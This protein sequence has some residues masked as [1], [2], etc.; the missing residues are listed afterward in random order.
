MANIALEL[1]ILEIVNRIEKEIDL[2]TKDPEITE[3]GANE[4][5]MLGLQKAIEICKSLEE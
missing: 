1:I 5:Y 4:Q 2:T 3:Y